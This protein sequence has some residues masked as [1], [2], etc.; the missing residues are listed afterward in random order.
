MN[1]LES[2]SADKTK[3][4]RNKTRNGQSYKIDSAQQEI[5]ADEL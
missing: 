1:I 3:K 5:N 2:V 4:M